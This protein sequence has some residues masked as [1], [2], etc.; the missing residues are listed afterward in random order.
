[1]STSMATERLDKTLPL[2]EQLVHDAWSEFAE[3]PNAVKSVPAFLAWLRGNN[4]QILDMVN[5]SVLAKTAERLWDADEGA[6]AARHRQHAS[7]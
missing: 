6:S 5:R 1:M 2:A 4:P 3:S 7:R